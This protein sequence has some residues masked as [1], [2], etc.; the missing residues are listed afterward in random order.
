MAVPIS[1]PE[2][3]V[4]VCIY[5]TFICTLT[6]VVLDCPS[7]CSLCNGTRNSDCHACEDTTLFRDTT[8]RL[9]APC[10]TRCRGA[11]LPNEDV[12]GVRTCVLSKSV[13]ISG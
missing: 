2:E 11:T 3:D 6:V 4:Q 8:N 10:V 9:G 13:G 7:M 12:F 1:T 5:S